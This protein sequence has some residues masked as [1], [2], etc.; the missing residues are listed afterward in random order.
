MNREQKQIVRGKLTEVFGKIAD[1]LLLGLFGLVLSLPVVTLG[2]SA[3]A[4][5]SVGLAMRRG[6]EGNVFRDAFSAFLRL[7]KKAT[8]VWLVYLLALLLLIGNSVFYFYMAGN[9]AVWADVGLGVCF[10]VALLWALAAGFVFPLLA[11]NGS[12]RL[13]DAIRASLFLSARHLGWWA[14][15]AFAWAL[16]AAAVWFVPFLIV[17]VPG[18]LLFWDSFC[19][20]RVLRRYSPDSAEETRNE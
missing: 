20:A 1:Y 7:F 19:N 16:L 12:M 3:A 11:Q 10:A 9:G 4:L 6:E 8:C 17:F 13:F 14:A 2:A 5:D 18:L 15:K